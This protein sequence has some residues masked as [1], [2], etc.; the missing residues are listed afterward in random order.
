MKNCK[1]ITFILLLAVSMSA[2]AADTKTEMEN[3]VKKQ[4]ILVLGSGG[5]RGLAHV[6]AIEELEKLGIVPDAIVG[7]SSGALVGALYAQHGDIAK[8][9]EILYE[10]TQDD[11]VDFSF[12]QKSAISTRVKLEKF[13]HENLIA[14]DFSTLKIPFVAVVTDLHKGEPV[15]L[16]QGELHAAVLS[17]A[18]LP[19]LF[20]PY[21]MGD[22]LFVDGG[23]CD[24][25]PVQFARKWK[26]GIIIASDIS[27]SLD[28]FDADNLPQVVRKS[29]EVAYQRLAYLSQ[30]EADILLLMNFDDIGSPVD[31]SANP[32]IYEKGKQVTRDKS[33]EIKKIVFAK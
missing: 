17:S 22:R 15:Y 3:D 7:C 12:F 32:R 29:F 21:Q 30:L 25:L 33:E 19:A 27:P 8:V 23:I 28:S 24:P 13:L 2:I 26:K 4:V 16:E 18:A 1:I 9:K 11:I 31:D 14:T 10:L 5:S 20:A 6:G